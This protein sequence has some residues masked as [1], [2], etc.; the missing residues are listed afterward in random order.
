MKH[1]RKH[2]FAL[3]L[4]LSLFVFLTL[5]GC[6]IVDARPPPQLWGRAAALPG[7][8]AFQW[9]SLPAGQALWSGRR[10]GRHL[11]KPGLGCN[12]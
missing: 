5:A 8:A 6:A 10:L 7:G 2:T 4:A 12:L 3:S 1:S 11:C 9:E